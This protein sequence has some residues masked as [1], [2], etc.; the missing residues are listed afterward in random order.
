QEAME[1][2]EEDDEG[3]EAAGRGAGHEGAGG[4][5]DIKMSSGEGLT[6]GWGSKMN[7]P[8]RCMITLSADSNTF[9]LVTT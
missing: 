4:S 8:T 2:D 1:K 7:K 6:L 9:P 5:I 3:D